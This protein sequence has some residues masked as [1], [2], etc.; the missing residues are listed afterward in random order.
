METDENIESQ[1]NRD[2]IESLQ[3]RVEDLDKINMDLEYRLGTKAL[4]TCP[5]VNNLTQPANIYRG[6]GENVH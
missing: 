4:Q 1:R 2:M 5:F 6:S 3:Q